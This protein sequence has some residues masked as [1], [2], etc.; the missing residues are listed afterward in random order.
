MSGMLSSQKTS[1]SS[2]SESIRTT[3]L[4]PLKVTYQKKGRE[5]KTGKVNSDSATNLHLTIQANY[6]Q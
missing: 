6:P 3:N 1:K 4:S 2:T 5:S